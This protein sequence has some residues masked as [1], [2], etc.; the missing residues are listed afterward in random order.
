LTMHLLIFSLNLLLFPEF[1]YAFAVLLLILLL[2][3]AT[4]NLT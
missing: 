1:D 4:Q 3:S 2:M